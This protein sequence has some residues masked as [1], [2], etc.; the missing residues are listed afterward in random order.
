MNKRYQITYETPE[1]IYELYISIT[2]NPIQDKT[3]QNK[4][5]FYKTL[6]ERALAEQGSLEAV[7]EIRNRIKLLLSLEG[8]LGNIRH[9]YPTLEKHEII[10]LLYDMVTGV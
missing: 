8:R 2:Q 5:Q 6:G 7:Y 1:V 9:K 3:E 10:E 4:Q